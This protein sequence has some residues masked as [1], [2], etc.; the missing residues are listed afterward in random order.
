MRSGL[1]FRQR[2]LAHLFF[3][4]IGETFDYSVATKE[5][6]INSKESTDCIHKPQRS[7]I[8]NQQQKESQKETHSIHRIYL[9]LVTAVTSEE[10]ARKTK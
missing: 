4:D 9:K 8:K 1:Y 7:K 2:T 5:A 10:G 3:S 6:S